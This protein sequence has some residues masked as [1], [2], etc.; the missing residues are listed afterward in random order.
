MPVRWQGLDGRLSDTGATCPDTLGDAL[1][2]LSERYASG[3]VPATGTTRDEETRVGYDATATVARIGCN[4]ISRSDR[5]LT[6]WPRPWGR[7]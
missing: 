4:H 1:T 6:A 3:I 5:G 2:P 7:R